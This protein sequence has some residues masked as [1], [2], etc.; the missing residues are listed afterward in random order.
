MHVRHPVKVSLQV[1]G[2]E[3][4]LEGDDIAVSNALS[5]KVAGFIL[6][7]GRGAEDGEDGRGQGSEL[8]EVNHFSVQKGM[9]ELI[10]IA[11]WIDKE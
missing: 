10:E 5:R 6:H 9:I 2:L 7:R 8:L 11:G 4:G 3:S 1:A